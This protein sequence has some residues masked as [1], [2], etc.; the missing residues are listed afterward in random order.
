MDAFTTSESY[1]YARHYRLE[2]ERINYV[3]NAVKA[4]IDAYDGTVDVL[5]LRRGGSDHRRLS[6]DIS[7][8]LSARPQMPPDMRRHVRYPE[9]MLDLQAGVYGLYHMSAPDVFYNREDLWTIASEV[10]LSEQRDQATQPMEPNFVLMK[11]PGETTHRVHR[12]PAVHAGQS[13]QSHRVD[14]RTERRSE[15]RHGDRL[16]LPQD[17][18]GGR[19]DA[20]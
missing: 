9:L 16:Q 2:N 20:D 3:R 7:D 19:P 17:T 11:L 13:E 15:L 5:R 4:T 14:C 10:G 12:N 8:A 6:R 1:P 18:A